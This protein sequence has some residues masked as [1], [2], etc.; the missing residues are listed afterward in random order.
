MTINNF[1]LN[2]IKGKLIFFI[3]LFLFLFSFKK[4]KNLVPTHVDIVYFLFFKII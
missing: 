4:T 2:E 1:L 3:F